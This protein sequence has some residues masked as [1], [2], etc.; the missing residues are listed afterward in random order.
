MVVMLLLLL[1]VA[2][3]M[4]VPVMMVVV[5]AFSMNPSFLSPDSLRSTLIPDRKG[6]FFS[7]GLSLCPKENRISA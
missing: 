6:C 4:V 3:A 5:M 7:L 2:V 1:L